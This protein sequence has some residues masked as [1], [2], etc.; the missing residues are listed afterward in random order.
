MSPNLIKLLHHNRRNKLIS[1]HRLNQYYIKYLI[2]H[3]LGLFLGCNSENF[4][5]M[6][7]CSCFQYKIVSMKGYH[8]LV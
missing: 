2:G 3:V 8:F 7:E 1:L 6:Q 5:Q 4:E